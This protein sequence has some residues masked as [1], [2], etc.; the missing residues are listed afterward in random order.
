MFLQLYQ[1][2]DTFS[3]CLPDLWSQS[4]QLLFHKRSSL[5]SSCTEIPSSFQIEKNYWRLNHK[6]YKDLTKSNIYFPGSRRCNCT[7]PFSLFFVPIMILSCGG[8]VPSPQ[9]LFC[10]LSV[11]RTCKLVLWEG[12]YYQKKRIVILL[13]TISTSLKDKL[14]APKSKESKS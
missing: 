5:I 13:S 3:Y 8:A 2:H 1:K 9:L 12:S 4:P 10:L 6:Y 11:W 7:T 14:Y